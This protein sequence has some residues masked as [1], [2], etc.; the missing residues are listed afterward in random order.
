A[1][2]RPDVEPRRAGVDMAEVRPAVQLRTAERRR[3]PRCGR[4]R[5]G[6][7]PG[8]PETLAE[9]FPRLRSPL[10]ADITFLGADSPSFRGA[11][12][13]SMKIV[14]FRS[15]KGR[16]FTGVSPSF[17]GAKGDSLRRSCVRPLQKS[18]FE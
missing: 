2:P 11:K 6:P 8:G 3:P 18:R 4:P 10:A 7:N 9:L 15:A 16:F 5:T 1:G 17:R 14:A 12:G 13:D